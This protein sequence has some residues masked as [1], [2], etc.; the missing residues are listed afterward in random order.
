[1]CV[2]KTCGGGADHC[3]SNDCFDSDGPRPCG[4]FIMLYINIFPLNHYHFDRI[5]YLTSFN[6]FLYLVTATTAKPETTTNTPGN[7]F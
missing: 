4:M 5:N 6:I 2:G 3:C 7:V 1:M